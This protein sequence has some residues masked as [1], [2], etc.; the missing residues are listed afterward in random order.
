MF[1]RAREREREREKAR[2]S[3][4]ESENENERENEREIKRG[5]AGRETERDGPHIKLS[6]QPLPR[7]QALIAGPIQPFSG[8]WFVL[9]IAGIRRFV[10]HINAIEK[11]RFAPPM[12]AGG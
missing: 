6:L 1:E 2:Q 12:R 7:Q 9:V 3:K 11:T 5:G 10:V 4:N 8:P